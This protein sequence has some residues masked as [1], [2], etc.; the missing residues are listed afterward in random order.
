MAYNEPLDFQSLKIVQ[1]ICHA[2]RQTKFRDPK[3]RYKKLASA[4]MPKPPGG[5]DHYVLLIPIISLLYVYY[6]S[7]IHI[8]LLYIYMYIS[9]ISL[10]YIYYDIIATS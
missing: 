5:R 10:L 1:C 8:Y 7:I 4:P 6:M 9:I 2:K 3:P